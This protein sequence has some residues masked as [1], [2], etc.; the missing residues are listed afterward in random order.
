METGA[1]KGDDTGSFLTAVLQ[2]VQA[3][4]GDG[5]GLRMAENAENTTFFSQAIRER[6]I[7][8]EREA[9]QLERGVSAKM[10]E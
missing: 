3:K 5:G 4:R 2:G 8:H 7:L 9:F 10:A 6:V 1:V